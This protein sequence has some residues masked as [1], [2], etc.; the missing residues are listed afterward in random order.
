MSCDRPA[1]SSRRRRSLPCPFTCPSSVTQ[2]T[3]NRAVQLLPA[4]PLVALSLALSRIT[5]HLTRTLAHWALDLSSCSSL[6]TQGKSIRLLKTQTASPLTPCSF[7]L[8]PLHA[9]LSS[10]SPFCLPW[11]RLRP[12]PPASPPPLWP[13]R[14]LSTRTPWSTVTSP[15]GTPSST[16]E[17]GENASAHRRPAEKGQRCC[18]AAGRARRAEGENTFSRFHSHLLP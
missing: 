2:R 15:C 18:R 10:A 12:L 7:S 4:L 1:S 5:R 6:R 16:S 9:F 13:P 17:T 8:A 3:A 11:R 14:R